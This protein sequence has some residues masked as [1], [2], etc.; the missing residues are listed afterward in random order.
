MTFFRLL[1][2]KRRPFTHCHEAA[3]ETYLIVHGTGRV[4]LGEELRD[5]GP[6]DAIRVAPS[7]PRAFE[8]GPDGLEFLAFGA[9]HEDDGKPIDDA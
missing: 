6:L 4:R 2:G 1:A 3:E 9:R 5:V 7:T 8:A